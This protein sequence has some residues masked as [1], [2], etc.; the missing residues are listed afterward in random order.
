MPSCAAECHPH[1][2]D[3]QRVRA[4]HAWHGVRRLHQQLTQLHVEQD[5]SALLPNAVNAING[6]RASC[7]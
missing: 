1:E 2:D 6:M 3:E 5:L 4:Q 7:S